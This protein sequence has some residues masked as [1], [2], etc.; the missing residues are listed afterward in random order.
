MFCL[1]SKL[2]IEPSITFQGGETKMWATR[3]AGED[4]Q[5]VIPWGRQSRCGYSPSEMEPQA[6]ESSGTCP[7]L[8]GE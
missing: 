2:K 6:P 4:A 5:K 8:A 3:V 7:G 1:V